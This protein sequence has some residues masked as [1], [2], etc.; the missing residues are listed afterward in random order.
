[1]DC[2][3]YVIT[4]TVVGRGRT[5]E[6]MARLAIEGGADIVQLRDKTCSPEDLIRT[7]RIIAE[8]ARRSGTLFIV[9]DHP[10]IAIACGADGVHLG[11]DDMPPAAARQIA[12]EGFIIGVSVSTA[13][14]AK[15]AESEGAD[16]LA[17]SPVFPTGSKPDA[18]GFCGISGIRQIRAATGLPL[19]AIGG[20]GPQNIREVIL[21]GADG[22]AVISAVVAKPD[23]AGAVRELKAIIKSA[24]QQ[25]SA[26]AGTRDR[27]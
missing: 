12:P 11:Q 26:L 20:I 17:A 9:N 23:I 14:E 13:A 4:D 25:R 8:I 24:R 6:E 21:A 15:K 2:E 27:D 19:V 16:Y 1:M 22:V 5:H 3:L 7:G 18:S 10:D